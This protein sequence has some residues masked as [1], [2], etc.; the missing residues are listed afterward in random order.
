MSRH[1]DFEALTVDARPELT[2]GRRIGVLLSHGFTG[3]PFSIRPWGRSLAEHGY[4][5]RVPLL[6]GHATTWQDLNTTTWDDWYGTLRA[7][8]DVLTAEHDAVV[9]GG[10]SMGGA[11]VLR[12]AAD[13]GDQVAGVMV[14]NPAL[15]SK[16]LDVK[17]LG[18]MK[19]LVPSTPGIADD[20]KKPGAKEHGYTRTPLRAI[21]SF[22]QAWKPLIADLT[23]VTAPLIYFRSAEDHVVDGASQPIILGGVSSTDVEVVALP[24][25]YHVATL[26]NDAET[27]FERSAEFVARVTSAG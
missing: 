25:S 14:V 24:D 17:A 8:F 27:I 4:G 18:V 13:V 26:D 9:L 2:D 19:R 22:V 20:I 1:P 12:L 5:V 23:R 3:S 11:L 10:L 16:R 7:E 21:H 15:A 6:P